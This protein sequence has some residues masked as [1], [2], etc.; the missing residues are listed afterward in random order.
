MTRWYMIDADALARLEALNPATEYRISPRKVDGTAIYGSAWVFPA[1][2]FEAEGYRDYWK[3]TAINGAVV[4]AEAD[5]L[6][7]IVNA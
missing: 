5:D 2:V 6:F 1:M 4:E 7:A 3:R